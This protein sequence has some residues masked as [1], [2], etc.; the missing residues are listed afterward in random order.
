MDDEIYK[1]AVPLN[2]ASLKG[3]EEDDLRRKVGE[4]LKFLRI[5]RHLTQDQIAEY[6]HVN[7]STYSYYELGKI[8]M[9]AK[10]LRQAATYYQVSVDYLL[11]IDDVSLDE[12]D[13]ESSEM[14][15]VM[16]TS[17]KKELMKRAEK[18]EMTFAEFM[19]TLLSMGMIIMDQEPDFF[20]EF[21]K[22]LE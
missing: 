18:S 12:D 1:D 13:M 20:K 21:A 4:R 2:K 22:L 19:S 10:S 8:S 5:S 11:G 3:T 16:P 14:K 6:L 7:R 9:N 15:I 17:M